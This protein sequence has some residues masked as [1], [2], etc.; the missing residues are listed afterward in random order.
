M[1]F[2]AQFIES[3]DGWDMAGEMHIQF[4]GCVLI[5]DISK[6]KKGELI[7]VIGFNFNSLECTFYGIEGNAVDTFQIK[8]ELV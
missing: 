4:Y 8:M 1:P 3:F 2:E 6:Y 7:K 5:R